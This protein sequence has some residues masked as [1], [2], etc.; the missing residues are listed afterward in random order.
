M[1]EIGKVIKIEKNRAVVL[2]SVSE[3]CDTC[4][5]KTGRQECGICIVDDGGQRTLSVDNSFGAKIGDEVEVFIP[6]GP[7]SKLSFLVFI[8]PIIAFLAGYFVAWVLSHNE[9]S[10]VIA[11][12]IGFV[13]TFYAL[14]IYEKKLNQIKKGALPSVSKILNKGNSDKNESNN[15]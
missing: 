9:V 3:H 6:E 13:L 5:Q 7:L 4:P 11:G 8:L 1:I 15:R 10:S 14:F 12:L 2:L